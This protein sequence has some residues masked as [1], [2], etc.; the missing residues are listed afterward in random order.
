MQICSDICTKHVSKPWN[1]SQNLIAILPPP[2]GLMIISI[3]D[4]NQKVISSA[5]MVTF[6]FIFDA[7]FGDAVNLIRKNPLIIAHFPGLNGE[8]PT[9]IGGLNSC[10]SISTQCAK[11]I[12]KR[13]I[14]Y[15]IS[16]KRT[17]AKSQLLPSE[18]STHI[19][20][21]HLYLTA[22]LSFS[23]SLSDIC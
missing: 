22:Y 16:L 2:Q 19:R 18:D 14:S 4:Y 21:T 6:Y 9:I 20:P 8:N 15:L 3:S 13:L 23:L 10:T 1:F 12:K 11:Y 17:E 7:F 5:S